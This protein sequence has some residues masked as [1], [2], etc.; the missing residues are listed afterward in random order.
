MKYETDLDAWLF[1]DRPPDYVA[2]IDAEGEIITKKYCPKCERYTV[3]P[4]HYCGSVA[5]VIFEDSPQFWE[6]YF[7]Y[8][9]FDAVIPMNFLFKELSK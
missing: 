5:L 8:F 1:P 6:D 2:Y 9:W 4:E 7:A 3:N